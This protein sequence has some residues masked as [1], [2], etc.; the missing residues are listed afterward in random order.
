LKENFTYQQ[1]FMLSCMPLMEIEIDE[2]EK[3][4]QVRNEGFRG[5]SLEIKGGV[6]EVKK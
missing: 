5:Q 3:F 1:D 6:K 2:P 4:I